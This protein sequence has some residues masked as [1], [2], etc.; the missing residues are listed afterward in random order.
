VTH[1]SGVH[2]LP[3]SA[4]S[5]SVPALELKGLGRRFGSLVALADIHLVVGANERRAVLG[6]NGAGKTTLFNTITGDL[7]PTSGTVKMFGRDITG[8]PVHHRARIGMRRTYQISKLF[9]NLSVIDSLFVACRGVSAGRFSLLRTRTDDADRAQAQAIANTVHLDEH[10]DNAV[11]SLSH[12]QQRQ[13]E[14]GF[15]LAGTPSLLLFD[16]PAAGL[17]PSERGDLVHILRS[18][19][20]SVPFIIIEHDLDVALRVSDQVTIMHNGRQFRE[21]TPAE[22]EADPEVQK[23]IWVRPLSTDSPV[24]RISGLE[25]RYGAAAAVQG[26][27]L[28]LNSGVLS[29]V[30]RNGMGKTTLCNTIVG[31]K[32]AAAGEIDFFGYALLGKRPDVIH[33]LGIGYVPQGRRTWPSLTVDEHLRIPRT[34]PTPKWTRERIYEIF[35]R[36]AERRNN[37]GNELSGGEKQMLAIGRALLG[38]PRLL[39]MD[40]PTEG[41]APVIVDQV[42]GLLRLLAA[43]EGMTILLVEQNLRVATAVADRVA[44]MVNGAIDRVVGARELRSDRALQQQLLGVGKHEAIPEPLPG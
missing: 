27:S 30:G 31:L 13:L 28:Q 8:L 9:S 44:I 34:P 15:A 24:L 5:S 33:R 2:D 42:E 29:I 37:G 40:E 17:S 38:D 32:A 39:I 18:L 12:G 21:G 4:N 10:R 23:S 36:L 20:A 7:T 22:I 16:E 6:S 41:L 19:P 1:S 25:V 26:V 3:T 43:K 11:A 14:I 35:P